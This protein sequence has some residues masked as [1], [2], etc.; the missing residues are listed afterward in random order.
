MGHP[1]FFS[2][3][4]DIYVYLPNLIGIVFCWVFNSN[5]WFMRCLSNSLHCCCCTAG[6]ARI[7]LTLGA[8]AFAFSYPELCVGAY[9]LA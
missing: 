8:L 3:H 6:Y 4:K 9:F 2:R 5:G 7:V 1:G